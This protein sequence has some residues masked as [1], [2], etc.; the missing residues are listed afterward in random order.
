MAP[1]S[2]YKMCFLG[3]QGVGKSSIIRV[4]VKGSFSA[5]YKVRLIRSCSGVPARVRWAAACRAQRAAGL[6]RH[7]ADMRATRSA[8]R[9][10]PFHQLLPAGNNWGRLLVKDDVLGGPNCQAS[11]LGHCR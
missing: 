3:D 7:V 1:L 4:F 6:C 2:K 11:D 8:P 5:D 10:S 9:T